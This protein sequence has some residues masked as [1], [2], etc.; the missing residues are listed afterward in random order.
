VH[1]LLSTAGDT[2]HIAAVE[3]SIP[4]WLG[5][6]LPDAIA[7]TM[8]AKLDFPEYDVFQSGGP[9]K[10]DSTCAA[11]LHGALGDKVLPFIGAAGA[12]PELYTTDR[13]EIAPIFYPC[14]H[15]FTRYLMVRTSA[16]YL[17]SLFPEMDR[18]KVHPML[19]AR[20]S[21]RMEQLRRDWLARLPEADAGP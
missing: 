7:Q 5:E 9:A 14:A 21:R 19:E 16:A 18:G 4:D 6:G 2:D 15:S 3:D 13:R 17:A 20:L 11:R 8:A 1:V 12:P 10:V